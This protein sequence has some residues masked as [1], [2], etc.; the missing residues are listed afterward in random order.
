MIC[1]QIE[2]FSCFL[3]GVLVRVV[4]TLVPYNWWHSSGLLDWLVLLI[5]FPDPLDIATPNTTTT[6][7]DEQRD[8]ETHGGSR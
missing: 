8:D 4:L 5:A 6:R 2:I 3:S 1:V 7:Q